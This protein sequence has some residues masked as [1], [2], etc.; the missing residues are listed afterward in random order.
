MCF[1][2]FTLKWISTL[3]V[4]KKRVVRRSCQ[5]TRVSAA[6]NSFMNA[7]LWLVIYSRIWDVWKW[8]VCCCRTQHFPSCVSIRSFTWVSVKMKSSWFLSNTRITSGL[9]YMLAIPA[10]SLQDT[11]VHYCPPL[12]HVTKVLHAT[13]FM[14]CRV[15][16]LQL[17]MKPLLNNCLFPLLQ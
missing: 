1:V 4:K 17:V 15:F 10:V 12:N 3:N 11:N 7:D 5:C 9:A 16:Y 6:S 2:D 14:D 13:Y 8:N